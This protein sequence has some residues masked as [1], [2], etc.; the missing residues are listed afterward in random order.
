MD[1]RNAEAEPRLLDTGIG[2]CYEDCPIISSCLY[3]KYDNYCYPHLY[4]THV[5]LSRLL[6][7]LDHISMAHSASIERRMWFA[8]RDTVRDLYNHLQIQELPGGNDGDV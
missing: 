1:L 3:C 8:V 2:I 7:L 6:G 4:Q 5:K